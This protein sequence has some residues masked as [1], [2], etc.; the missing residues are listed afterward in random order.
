[1]LSD[2]VKINLDDLDDSN[3]K[4]CFARSMALN[5]SQRKYTKTLSK[6]KLM[7]TTQQSEDLLEDNRS[8]HVAPV[9]VEANANILRKVS[10]S[11][12]FINFINFH[13]LNQINLNLFRLFFF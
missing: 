10:L 5:S 13:C 7:T 12:I 2:R 1:M 3:F 6:Q 8:N 9:T 11:L 4:S